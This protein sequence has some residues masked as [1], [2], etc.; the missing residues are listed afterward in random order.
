MTSPRLSSRSNEGEPNRLV[1]GRLSRRNA[2]ESL[3]GSTIVRRVGESRAV[4][5]IADLTPYEVTLVFHLSRMRIATRRQLGELQ[6]Q[7]GT[8]LAETRRLQR[9]LVGLVERRVLARLERGS[10]GRRGGSQGPLYTLDVVAQ[11]LIAPDSRRR[12]RRP[13]FVGERFTAHVLAV[14]DTYVR[15][16][17]AA[18]VREIELIEFQSEPGCWTSYGDRYGQRQ[19]LK[20]DAFV[21]VAASEWE[22]VAFVEVDLATESL[23]TIVQ[24]AK[25]YAEAYR[26]GDEQQR[27]GL[28]PI[29]LWLTSSQRRQRALVETLARLPAEEWRLH[30]IARLE[31]V[32]DV[33]VGASP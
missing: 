21:R 30:R 5:T 13:S 20:P 16:A 12:L 9:T 17:R 31:D 25:V 23:T 3:G 10:G 26:A 14:G 18:R 29:V 11:R 15:L 2:N 27:L 24:K 7:G 32:V 1:D 19:T 6:P 22:Y 8:S 28:F 4:A 33:L